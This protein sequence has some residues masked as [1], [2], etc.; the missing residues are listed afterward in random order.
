M[1]VR[2]QVRQNKPAAEAAL[3]RVG[4]TCWQRLPVQRAEL[5]VDGAAYFAALRSAIEQAQRSIVILGWDIR[6]DLV[7]DPDHSAETLRDLLDRVAAERP[8]LQVRILI[9][10]WLLLYS[11]DR[12]PLPWWHL[13]VRTH[14]RVRFALDSA[15]PPAGCHHEKL[16]VVDG[17]LAFVGGIDLTAGRWDTPEHRP[18]EPRRSPASGDNRPPFHDYM[19][20]FEGDAAAAVEE[21]ALDRWE[22]ATGEHVEPTAAAEAGLWPEG[23]EPGFG[24]ASVAIARTRP[25]WGGRPAVREIESLYLAA[26]ARARTSIHIENQY[27]TADRIARALAARLAEPDGPEVVI[28][29]P[30]A[31]EGLFETAVMD[32]GRSRYLRRLRRAAHRPDRL[33]IVALESTEGEDSACINVH[34]KLIIVD[35]DLLCLGSANLANRS[36]GLDT[37]CNVAIAAEDEPTRAAIRMVRARLLAEHLQAEPALVRRRL[38]QSGGRAMP[39]IAELGPGRMRD[40]RLR[41]SPIV[42]ELASPARLADL[43]EPLTSR[44]IAKHLAPPTRR[45]RLR[46]LSFR[47]GLVVAI[48]TAVAFLIGTGLLVGRG[49]VEW[50]FA[51]AERHAASPLGAAVVLA[52]FVLGSQLLVPVTLMIALTAAIAGPLLGFTYA[53]AGACAAGS[54]TFLIGRILG[55][56]RVRRVAGRRLASLS[57]RLGQHGVV[58]MALIRLLPIAPFSLVNLVAGVSEIRLRDFILGSAIGLAPGVALMTLFG[59]RLGHWLRR[60]DPWDLATLVGGLVLL[61]VL[62]RL[63]HLWSARPAPA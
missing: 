39:V 1:A 44:H 10:D 50:G 58:A 14:E 28:V 4:E 47:V 22:A 62:A 21:L 19:L 33:R 56:R 5:L 2:S 11:L 53:M 46:D 18:S 45:R 43:D 29:T 31:C 6:A 57:L 27:L 36:M 3:F 37:E 41:L 54:V 52:T 26:I 34:G 60:P 49:W 9:W 32:V 59:D 25:A 48:V 23:V 51:L 13:G 38:E 35:D 63:L 7:L 24:A 12:Q 40:L 30:K 8:G 20:M 55:R 17:S 16:V 61:L 15:H 42:R